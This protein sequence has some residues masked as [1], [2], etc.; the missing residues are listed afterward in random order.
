MNDFFNYIDIAF[1]TIAWIYI[2]FA[3]GRYHF[4]GKKPTKMELLFLIAALA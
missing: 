1:K 3:L 4:K 2:A